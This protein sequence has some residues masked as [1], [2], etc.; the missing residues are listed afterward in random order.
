[1]LL[2]RCFVDDVCLKLM[3]CKLLIGNVKLVCVFVLPFFVDDWCLN[4][5]LGCVVIC[6][7]NLVCVYF[8]LPILWVVGVCI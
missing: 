1:M 5:M 4:L 6:Y 8:V 2:C 7:I 3:I